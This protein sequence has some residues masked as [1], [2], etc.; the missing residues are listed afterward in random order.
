[1]GSFI[2]GKLI[3]WLRRKSGHQ[4][5]SPTN[6]SNRK[7]LAD[8]PD[9][10]FKI[11]FQEQAYFSAAQE[12]AKAQEA[13]I[14]TCQELQQSQTGEP[15]PTIREVGTPQS[16]IVAESSLFKLEYQICPN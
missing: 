5:N 6:P 12:L 15:A 8:I 7:I 3:D 10:I 9:I 2:L 4:V 16:L 11:Q 1:M 13:I 14:A